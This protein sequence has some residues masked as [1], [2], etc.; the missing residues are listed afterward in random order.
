[1]WGVEFYLI[2]N[3]RLAIVGSEYVPPEDIQFEGGAEPPDSNDRIMPYYYG[4]YSN[5]FTVLEIYDISARED[6]SLLR[7]VSMD[8]NSI[9][10]RVI[11]DIVYL[12][13]NKQIWNIPYNQADSPSILPYCRDTLEGEGFEPISFDDIYYIPDSLDSNYLLIGAIDV[14]DDGAEFKPEAYLGAGSNFYMSK[15]AIYITIYR[16]DQLSK[17]RGPVDVAPIVTERTDILR[18]AVSGT[19]VTYTGMGTVDGSPINQYSMDEYKDY[20]RIA[21]TNWETGTYV[22]VLKTSNMKTVGRTEPLAPGERM[23]SMRFVGDMGYVVTFQNMDPLFTIDLSDPYNPKVLG[24]LKIPGF[25]QYLHPVGGGLMLGIGR[26][27][28]VTYTRDV[29]GVERIV[30][31]T[32]VGLKAS[33][34]DVSNPFDPK[35][36]GTL[37]LG[38]GWTE[39]CD[40]PRALMCDASRG[41]YGFMMQI[42]DNRGSQSSDALIL[43]VDDGKLT[44]DATLKLDKDFWVY[45]SRLCFIGNSLYLVHDTGIVVYDYS[46]YVM[47]GSISF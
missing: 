35:E 32:D 38:E 25:S 8:G 2:G 26:D 1:M 44:I 37:A 47:Q 12:V 18:F 7:R 3:D 45:N 30:G 22:T 23:Q 33:L 27:V 31:T 43:C 36:I 4:W 20:F 11:G 39:V 41:L 24:E 14:Y 9:S 28:Q 21:T 19:D 10:T 5:S 6:P 16:W 40:N 42:W 13:T 29:T 15:N 46:S 34:F 17:V